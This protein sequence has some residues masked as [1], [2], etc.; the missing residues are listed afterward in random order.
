MSKDRSPA[1]TPALEWIAAGVGLALLLLVFAVIARQA[2]TGGRAEPPAI[3]IEV[4]RIVP[5]ASGFLV[6]F[7]AINEGGSTAAAVEV[8]GDLTKGRLHEKASATLDYV[9]G[10]GRTPGG[11]F[12]SIDPRSGSLELRAG[13]FQEP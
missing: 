6:E 5:V 4:K 11:L 8:Q 7:E 3:S 10:G 9:S 12:F 1:R 2:L 13:G